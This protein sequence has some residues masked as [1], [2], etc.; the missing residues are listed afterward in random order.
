MAD[1]EK[2]KPCPF[3]GE[4]KVRKNGD[5]YQV[6]CINDDCPDRDFISVDKWQNAYCWKEL[7]KRD[8]IIKV[9]VEK[10][11]AIVKHQEIVVGKGFARLSTTAAIANG[12]ILEIERLKKEQP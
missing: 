10:F 4:N 9:C 3:C 8:A 2:L 12:A 11:N 5:N 7:S 6:W 1:K